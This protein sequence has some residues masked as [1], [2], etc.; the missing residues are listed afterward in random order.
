MEAAW[1]PFL[2]WP[3]REVLVPDPSLAELGAG[4]VRDLGEV[5][6]AIAVYASRIAQVRAAIRALVGPA[7]APAWLPP[8]PS[9]LLAGRAGAAPA[10]IA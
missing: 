10:A 8:D 9:P 1:R 6:A 4:L 2:F 3:A 7:A 5:R